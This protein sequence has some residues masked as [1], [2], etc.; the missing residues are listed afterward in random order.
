MDPKFQI[1]TVDYVADKNGFHPILNK[2]PPPLPSDSPVVAAAKERHLKQ[3]AAI[4][5]ER[6]ALP[7]EVLVPLDTLTVE[8]AKARH[9][10][11]YEKIAEEHRRLAAEQ[12]AK[13]LAEEAAKGDN[14][15]QE[16]VE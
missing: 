7:G 2:T 12:E 3:Y 1:R 6:Q 10:S 4:A 14:I 5:N 16:H 8:R 9:L 13:K 15:L 11:L